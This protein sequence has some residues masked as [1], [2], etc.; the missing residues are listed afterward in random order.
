MYRWRVLLVPVVHKRHLSIAIFYWWGIMLRY[1]IVHA[2]F[3]RRSLHVLLG[4]CLS[5]L[6]VWLLL[7]IVLTSYSFCIFSSSHNY[8]GQSILL[9]PLLEMSRMKLHLVSFPEIITLVLHV[10]MSA[11]CRLVLLVCLVEILWNSSVDA[12]S[13]SV[14]VVV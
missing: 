4:W 9:F 14:D 11:N 2:W 5:V 8:V 6:L 10:T 12:M 3:S 7:N 13:I 1:Y